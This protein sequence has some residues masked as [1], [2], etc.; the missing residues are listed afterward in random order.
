LLK[1]PQRLGE[2]LL[3]PFELSPQA[4]VEFFEVM[5]AERVGRLEFMTD[6]FAFGAEIA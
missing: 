3:R 2:F 4:R 5:W 6:G 1:S